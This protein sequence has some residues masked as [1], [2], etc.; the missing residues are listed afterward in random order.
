MHYLTSS[1]IL[2]PPVIIRPLV[3]K[4]ASTNSTVRFS[5]PTIDSHG[6]SRTH[7]EWFRNGQ[8]IVPV[9]MD[10]DERRR[11]ILQQNEL[12]IN[13]VRVNDAAVYQCRLSNDAGSVS[14]SARL[15]VQD[16]RPRFHPNVFPRRVFVVEGSKLVSC[17][18]KYR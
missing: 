6:V 4:I 18:L 15:T 1:L 13:N 7:T 16:S 9:L 11:F 14:S 17:L 3:S 8:P 5:C 10:A 2:A 12:A